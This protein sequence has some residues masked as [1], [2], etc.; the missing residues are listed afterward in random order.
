MNGC[1][2]FEDKGKMLC[3]ISNKVLY[4][5]DKSVEDGFNDFKCKPEHTFQHIP[6]KKTER[7]ILYITAP[8]G[9]GKSYYTR[10]YIEQYH[11]TYPKREVMIVSALES[12]TTLD[13]LTYLKRINIKNPDFLAMDLSA[14]DFKDS[15]IVFDDTD[16]IGLKPIKIKVMAIL[17]SILNTGRHHNVSVIYTS[18]LA[19]NGLETKNILN[20]C[21]S[22]T[23][24]PK[25]LGGKSSKYLLDN[26]L[27]LDKDEIKRIKNVKGSRW[28]TIVKSYPMVFFS[29]NEAWCRTNI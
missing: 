27:G 18:H 13:K 2:N 23:I 7:S 4:I 3:K 17:T 9:S 6:D 15:L 28:C 22:I 10:Q 25:N 11:K 29:E 21:H 5:N 24:F 20:E 12:D 19:C 16:S 8:S 26:Y 14:A 1:L